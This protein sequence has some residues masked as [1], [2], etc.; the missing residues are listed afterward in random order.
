MNDDQ[1][2]EAFNNLKKESS[3]PRIHRVKDQLDRIG[4]TENIISLLTDDKEDLISFFSSSKDK[5][6]VKEETC[7]VR[8]LKPRPACLPLSRVYEGRR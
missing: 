1:N 7:W 2:D 6:E 5:E 8:W 4:V 3:V